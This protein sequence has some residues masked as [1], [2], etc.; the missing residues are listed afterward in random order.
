MLTARGVIN[1]GQAHDILHEVEGTGQEPVSAL[2]EFGVFSNADEFWAM[3]A[4]DLGAE[5]Y[6][7]GEFDPPKELVAIL[8]ASMAR[9]YGVFPI[10][11]DA[12]NLYAAF[13]DPLNPQLAEDLRFAIGKD[14]IPVVGRPEHIQ[15]LIDKHY[16]SGALDVQAVLGQL[17]LSA[18]KATNEEPDPNSAP[19]VRFVDLVLT[20]AIKEK[21][22]DIHFEPFEHEFKIRYRVDGALYEMAPPPVHLA[23]SIISRVKVMSNMNIA[24]R[25]VPQDGRIM[26]TV[27][28]KPVDMRVSSLPTQHGESVVL[29]VLDRSSIQL[30]LPDLGMSDYLY[31][32]IQDTINKPNG[33]FIVTGPTGAGKTTTLYAAL[34]EIN[35]VDAKLLTAEDPVEY[36]L[37]GIMQVPVNEAVGL[38]FARALRA[39]LRQDPDRI[40]VG[41]LRDLETASIAIQA[42][43]TGHLVLSTLH[44]NDAAGA[45]TRLVDLGVEPF[46]IAA[47]L[48][49]ILAQRLLRTICSGCKVPYDPSLS[50]LNQLGLTQDDT[51]GKQFFTGSGCPKCGNSGYKGRKGLFELMELNDPLRELIT[52]RAPTLVLKQKAIEVGMVTLRQDGIRCIFDGIT[53]IEEVLK[54]T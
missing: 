17:G 23:N 47:T 20:Q 51:A 2:L 15:A 19:I 46:L 8:P 41:E 7:L 33:I 16:G 52:K 35:T 48:E 27:E 34:R 5:H 50:I 11:M 12:K 13:T 21:A 9:L 25:R 4:E 49:G 18:Q 14:I 42:S 3:V 28:G 26:T 40:M 24:E 37:D 36:E 44:T 29:R 22:S 53:T 39:F 30:T 45:V 54:Y 10:S 32:F 43:L 1:D 38:T 31:R 6:D